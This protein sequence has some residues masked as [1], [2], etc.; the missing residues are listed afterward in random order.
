[1]IAR[2]SAR[3]RAI[4]PI[5]SVAVPNWPWKFFEDLSQHHEQLAQAVLQATLDEGHRLSR[6]FVTLPLIRD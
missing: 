5:A 1:L 2:Q 6:I 3:V 4:A